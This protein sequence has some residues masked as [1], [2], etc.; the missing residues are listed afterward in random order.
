MPFLLLLLMLPQED[1]QPRPLKSQVTQVQPMTGLV[2]WDDSEHATAN[3]IQLEFFYLTYAAL[4]PK[5]G[6]IDWR[7]I[8]RRLDAIKARK[9]QA[10]VRFHDTYVGKPS[11]VPDYIRKLPDYRETTAKSEG[12]DTVFPDWSHPEMAR[13][14]IEFYSKV[15]EKYDRDPRIAYVE[16]GF[17]LWSEYHIYDGPM[18][19]GGTFPA[20][21]FQEKFLRHLAGLF[22]ATPWMISIDAAAEETT[23]FASKRALVDLSFGVFDDSF[24]CEQHAKENAPNWAFFGRDRW[25][26]AP[27]G[28]EFSYYTKDDQKNALA[29][30]GPHG[31][32]FE[33]A[34]RDFHLTFIIAN[35][36]PQYQQIERIR[37]AGLGCGYRFRVTDY[38]AGGGKSILTLTN[39]GIAPLYHEAF[40]AVAGRRSTTSLKGLC[41]GE[42]RVCEVA[43]AGGDVTIESDRLVP[44][45]KIEFDADLPGK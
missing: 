24:L 1:L 13:F 27:A 26:R 29:P 42:N 39:S 28:G 19:L 7:P 9:H 3:P 4:V 16:T 41:P 20:K 32:P 6:E 40:V 31:V 21:E 5:R 15:A 2:F 35:D 8:E 23:P 11:G 45:Q 43:A 30:K 34:A 37:A 44:G 10:I 18:K 14:Y 22:K 12:K 36:Q 38:R 25:K 33:A 17:G